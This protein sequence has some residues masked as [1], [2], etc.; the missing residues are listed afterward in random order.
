MPKIP[1]ALRGY[2]QLAE[3]IGKYPES[4]IFRRFGSLNAKNTLYYQAEL[5]YLEKKLLEIENRDYNMSIRQPGLHDC[6]VDWHWLGGEQRDREK[7]E[8]LEI[9]TKIRK[10]LPMYS[11]SRVL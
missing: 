2:S 3:Y 7:E 5:Q 1:L 8:Q 9:V 11:M 6:T 4:G 10:I